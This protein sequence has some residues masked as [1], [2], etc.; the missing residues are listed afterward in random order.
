MVCWGVGC[1]RGRGWRCPFLAAERYRFLVLHS[2]YGVETFA[3]QDEGT[4]YNC[5]ALVVTRPKRIAAM[6]ALARL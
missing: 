6:I 3:I 1:R 4:T 5:P 2:T